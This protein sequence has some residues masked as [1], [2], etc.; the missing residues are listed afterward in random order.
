MMIQGTGNYFQVTNGLQEPIPMMHEAVSIVTNFQLLY[1]VTT[2]MYYC[3]CYLYVVLLVMCLICCEGLRS[4][5]WL[6]AS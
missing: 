3:Y 1:L 2:M 4:G 5:S 6:C